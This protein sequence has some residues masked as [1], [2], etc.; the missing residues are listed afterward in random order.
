MKITALSFWLAIFFGQ[1]AAPTKLQ[2][3]FEDAKAPQNWTTIAGATFSIEDVPSAETEAHKVPRGKCL[4]VVAKRGSGIVTSLDAVPRDWRNIGSVNF[5]AKCEAPGV[6]VIEMR[7]VEAD[8]KTLAWRKFEIKSG[9]WQKISLPLAWFRMGAGRVW[10]WDSIRYLELRFRQDCEIFIDAIQS[11]PGSAYRSM[12]EIAKVAFPRTRSENI[13][14]VQNEDAILMTNCELDAPK[15]LAHLSKVKVAI[16]KQLPFLKA[17]MNKPILIVFANRDEYRAFVPR[18]ATMLGAE[19]RE[20]GSEG[21]TIEG[22]ATSFLDLARGDIRPVFTHEFVHSYLHQSMLL[23]NRSDWLQEGLAVHFQ[24]KFHAE[25]NFAEN[26]QRV[27]NDRKLQMPLRTLT[28]GQGI[29]VTQY[30]QAMTVVELLMKNPK[31][32]GNFETLVA[33]FTKAGTTNLAP[34]IEKILKTNFDEL[35]KDWRES[36]KQYMPKPARKAASTYRSENARN[37]AIFVIAS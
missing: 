37:A 5:W 14:L 19:A 23:P 17:P 26:M 16:T 20:P 11:I 35:E 13:H 18:F 21:V 4:H 8:R 25:A 9:D 6:V 28:S 2:F 29:P 1:Q 32:S 22:I 7:M 24:R 33:E 31:Y 3:D 10:R 30:W 15:V 12:Q 36:C 34:H 27:M